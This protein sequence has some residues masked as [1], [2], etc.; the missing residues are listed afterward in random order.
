MCYENAL[1]VYH[2]ILKESIK[3]LDC[4]ERRNERVVYQGKLFTIYEWDQELYDGTITTFE[5][6]ERNGTVTMFASHNGKIVI[7]EQEQPHWANSSFCVP[8]GRIDPGE[9]PLA[10]AKRELLEE[11]GLVTEEWEHWFD[12]GSRGNLTWVNHFYFAR[13]C[14][15]VSEPHL[16]PGEKITHH[17]YTPK[18][19]FELLENPYFR[20][21]EML[22]KLCDI[23]D[24]KNL[25]KEFLEKLGITEE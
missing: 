21:Q 7:Q 15:K 12:G 1:L 20:H 14:K 2:G 18:E 16:D 3:I 6:A 23:R 25:R 22:S 13:N 4:M 8:G 5:R 11:E 17:L 19:F 9:E 10:T 24:N